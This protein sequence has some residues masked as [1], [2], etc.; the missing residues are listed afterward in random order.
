MRA[1]KHMLQSMSTTNSGDDEND[2]IIEIRWFLT[3]LLFEKKID[4]LG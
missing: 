1:S 4:K 3:L 2:A